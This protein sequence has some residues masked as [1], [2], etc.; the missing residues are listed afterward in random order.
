MSTITIF[1]WRCG[2]LL[3]F[4]CGAAQA[5]CYVKADAGGA[6]SGASWA[7]AYADLQSA[8]RDAA[9]VETWVAA[10]TYKPGAARGDSFVIRPGS[11]VYGGF[12]GNESARTQAD[13]IA[14]AAIL[15]GDIGVI[16]DAG[17][18]SWHVVTMDGTT[19]TGA[20]AASTVLDGFTIRDGHANGPFPATLGAGLYCTGAASGR[21]CDPSLARLRFVAN[22]ASYGGAIALRA[23]GA[24]R[25]SPRLSDV[26]FSGNSATRLGGAIYVWAELNGVVS[27][28]IERVTFSGNKADKGGAIYNSGGS[29]GGTANATLV[30]ATFQGNDASLG[31][32]IGNGGAIY[33]AGIG[34]S[35]A[36]TLTN[37]TF[38]G[39]TA[40]GANHFGGAMVN[41]GIGAKPVVTNA[42][43]WGN[44]ANAMPEFYNTGGAQPAISNSLVKGG[45]P[46]G[47]VCTD[48][49]DADPLLGALADNGGFGQTMLP[50]A[51]SP[52][53]DAGD[54][55]RCPSTDQRGKPRP[56]GTQCDIGAVEVVPPRT[57]YVDRAA[58]GA[59]D[60]FAW[61]SAYVDL[62]SA[63]LEPTCN[64][65]WAAKGVYK[66]T[67]GADRSIS[68]SIRPG[69]KLYG[70]FAGNE[71]SREQ[72]DPGANRTVL[73][74][75]I[76]GNDVVDADG[77]VRDGDQIAGNNTY[78]VVIMDGTTAA[79]SIGNDTVLDGFAIT[80]GTGWQYPAYNG[81]V[82]GGLYCNGV[83]SGHGCSPTLTRLW[84]SGNRADW[85]AALMA[86]GS[87]D[88]GG[89]GGRAD[90]V[91]SRSTFSGNRARLGG[92]AGYL[93]QTAARILQSTFGDN[94]ATNG[95]G[96]AIQFVRGSPSL[97][98]VTFNGNAAAAQG[99]AILSSSAAL[100]MS[101]LILWGNSGSGGEVY[102]NAG[103]V[104]LF[105]S[106][107]QG[108]CPANVSCSGLVSG[109]PLLGPLQDNGGAAP[110][111]R[112]GIGGAALDAGNAAVCG[113]APY[114]A[115]QRG[116]ARPQGPA[117]DFGALELRQ[118]QFVVAV[119]GP[120]SVATDINAGSTPA[121]GGI[122]GCDE[123]GE[124][125]IAGY[126]SEPTAAT[127]VLDLAPAMHAH[128]DS[129]SDSCGA[130][131]ASIGVLEGLAYTIAP[132]EADC[133]VLASFVPDTH[134]IGGNVSGLA[135]MGLA[136]QINGGETIAIAADG[137]F[138]FPTA[139]PWDMQYDVQ[140]LTPPTQPWQT[141]TVTNGSGTIGDADVTDIA[142]T[143]TTSTYT[144]GGSVDGLGGDGLVLRLND[145]ETLPITVDGAFAFTTALA[146]GDTYAVTVEQSPPGQACIAERAGG[147]IG[148]SDVTDI[149]VHCAAL[150]PRL[151]L[152]IDDGREFTRYGCVVDYTVTLRNDGFSTAVD[153]P[154]E[155]TLS[156]VFDAAFAHWQCFGGDAGAACTASGDGV[157]HDLATL[158][159]GRSLTWR[160]SVPVRSD[161]SEAEATFALAL[162]G[163]PPQNPSD[164]NTLVL[165]RDGLDVPYGDGAQ[166][167][168]ADAD[169]ILGGE[170]TH[171][172]ELPVP[173]GER[174]DVVLV[175]RGRSGE[176]EV[177][178]TPLDA[179]TSLLRL[180][181]V[182]A[183]GRERVSPWVRAKPGATLA[184]GSLRTEE[185]ASLVL[186][187]GA[188]AL[189][190]LPIVAGEE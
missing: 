49:H 106:V 76:D 124:G 3:A 155:A 167:V 21:S 46:S 12:A 73:S 139:L 101:R 1:A 74:G 77:I 116:V 100:T 151:L 146:S 170:A 113:T 16:G 182:E 136:L 83:G 90:L 25:A 92:G 40:N 47:A 41:E 61:A 24:G 80:A 59:N 44:Q 58:N 78:N 85:G 82:A 186:L 125:C 94:R 109:D 89:A 179:A 166:V 102:V 143:C 87:D 104:T 184:L 147:T 34:G 168:G 103:S 175:V 68:F 14:N 141:C 115:D 123:D 96:G 31:T 20:I 134:A 177:Q 180:S 69:L 30:N 52:A 160:I 2:A 112:P 32:S 137:P 63:L 55:A 173:S 164:T 190:A 51:G 157:L 172:F 54:D 13:P 35:G 75:D 132:L 118:A 29:Q 178:R 174:L 8:L 162:G 86:D 159:P 148:G 119:V 79:G 169:A 26:V 72:A 110:T 91:V 171:A 50:A 67:A 135:G 57:C 156:T 60:G 84:F 122:A 153:V 4:G 22:A 65:V 28:A 127:V 158:P 185:G 154:L 133:A 128:L 181:R 138:A 149:A 70:G 6:N 129:I 27:P 176:L 5:V 18:N 187:D 95:I 120:G 9:C 97:D 37:V 108:A 142:V 111:M 130:D 81:S 131:G 42:I 126:A 66:P 7:D 163:T 23:D 189:A 165:L 71:T 64:E 183:G 62:Q 117:C 48:V 161:G 140:V 15:S 121:S 10:G 43:F 98:Q 150:P 38:S 19:A 107:A 145:G 39:N 17:D 11:S 45:C 105:D 99:G 152:A 93:S 88:T 36:M 188:Q 56:Q 144:V 53:I 114:D 33:N